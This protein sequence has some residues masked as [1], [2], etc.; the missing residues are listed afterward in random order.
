LYTGDYVWADSQSVPFVASG[1]DQFLVRAQGG[2]GINRTNPAAALDVNGTASATTLVGG[3]LGLGLSPQ[4]PL[5]MLGGQG[6]ARFASTNTLAG[7][8]LELKNLTPGATNLGAIKFNNSSNAY[9]GQIAYL[10][11]DA[12]S[13]GVGG[14]ERMNLSGAGLSVNGTF[15]STSDRNAKQDFQPVDACSVL[16][17]VAQ[18][19][20]QTWAYKDDPR[21]RHLGP[22]AQD[23]YAAFG[24][25]ADDRHIA[26]VDEGGV[27]LAAIQGLL[28]KLD[29]K[30]AR[31]DELERRLD[32]LER[33]SPTQSR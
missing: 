20:L 18:L 4:L 21:T 31:I 27:A 7:S 33:I 29:E 17:K 23:F 16:G 24:T 8:V 15:V 22:M 6:A 2:V 30:D 32:H 9:P 13:F 11:T 3:S 5:D 28:H 1:N 10:S 12:L 14:S 25:G 19:P 26:V